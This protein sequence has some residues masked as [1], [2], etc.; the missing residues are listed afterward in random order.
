MRF[1]LAPIAFLAAL[2]LNAGEVPPEIAARFVKIISSGKVACKDATMA[3]A[4]GGAGCAVDP[5]SKFA[6]AASEGEVKSLSA[7]G[8]CVITNRVEWLASGGTIAIV[9]E[10]GTPQMYIHSGNLQASGASLPEAVLKV[11]KKH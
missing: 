8:K 3:T 9:E 6:W 7:G 1:N 4:L 5:G 2:S 10:G 11:S